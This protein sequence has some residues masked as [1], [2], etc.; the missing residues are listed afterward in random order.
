[1]IYDVNGTLFRSF[2]SA[3]GGA[4]K[5]ATYV[6]PG[7]PAAAVICGA[8]YTDGSWCDIGGRLLQALYETID[9]AGT[10]SSHPNST[11]DNRRAPNEKTKDNKPPMME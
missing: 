7:G 1:M 5:S 8:L 10:P 4:T 11:K 3:G 6:A 2:L 9:A